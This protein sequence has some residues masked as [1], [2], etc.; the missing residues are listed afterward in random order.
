MVEPNGV[1][2]V[3]DSGVGGL[4]VVRALRQR[5]PHESLL[6]IADS[7]NCPYGAKGPEAISRLAEGISRYLIEHR[8]KAVVVACN[9]ASAAAL[10]QLRSAFPVIP[11]IGMVPAVK[12]AA[13]ATTSGVVGVLATPGT[14]NGKL[15]EDVVIHHTAG[16]RVIAAACPGL[17]ELIEAGVVAG[18]EIEN[19]LR[20]CIDPLVCAG[21]D[22]LVLGCTHY[23]F[24]IPTIEKLYAPHLQVLEPSDA[25]AR[26]V[27]RVLSEHHL[28]TPDDAVGV[29]TYFS[30][31]EPYLL[32]CALS[33][34]LGYD[35][36]VG[37]LHW[38]ENQLYAGGSDA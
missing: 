31:G 35:G 7:A 3:F 22:T 37:Q 34:F 32:K 36:Q 18:E 4:S 10:G 14:L 38:I 28:L 29:Q 24:L 23:P 20:A 27:E 8:A 9:T 25:V 30:T 12:P 17:V 19:L 15:Y 11:F 33:Q 26:Q 13:Q 5:L 6:Y 16:V 2:G 21:A 1:L